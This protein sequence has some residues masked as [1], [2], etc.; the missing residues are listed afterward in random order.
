MSTHAAH[1][2]HQHQPSPVSAFTLVPEISELPLGETDF[3]FRILG[4]DGVAVT[5]FATSHEKK[6]HFILV[7]RDLTRFWH[8]HPVEVGGGVWSV[9]LSLPEAGAYRIFADVAPAGAAAVT[10]EADLLAGGSHTPKPVP[11]PSSVFT[12]EGYEVR[13][14][15]ELATGHGGKLV[16]TVTKDERAVLDLQPYLGAYGHL[17]AIRA[18]DL[19]YVHVHPDDA[20]TEPGPEIAFHAAVPGPGTYRLFLDFQHGGVIRTADFTAAAG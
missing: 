9:R 13:L 20:V 16:F 7:S 1:H 6:L 8:L 11:A 14:G 10:L 12:G 15:G 3:R 5:D 18:D 4:A 19:S 17:V 2:A